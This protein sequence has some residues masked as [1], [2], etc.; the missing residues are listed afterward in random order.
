MRSA[1]GFCSAE[2]AD[3]MIRLDWF[4]LSFSFLKLFAHRTTAHPSVEALTNNCQENCQ[5]S[6][7]AIHSLT[8]LL[9]LGPPANP[10]APCPQEIL[11]LCLHPRSLCSSAAWWFRGHGLVQS[12]LSVTSTIKQAGARCLPV[13]L[14][15]RWSHL[16]R[17][18][19]NPFY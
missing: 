17:F 13:P 2:C 1:L 10:T 19:A 6:S 15:E 12:K 18:R 16:V 3:P 5:V 8:L 7:L 4:R 9:S 11:F 14:L